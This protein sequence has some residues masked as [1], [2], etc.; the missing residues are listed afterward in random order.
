MVDNAKHRTNLC[1]AIVT[2]GFNMGTAS[3]QVLTIGFDSVTKNAV[4]GYI[5]NILN[6]LPPMP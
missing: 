2:G 1:Q 6:E 5:C 3:D 4:E